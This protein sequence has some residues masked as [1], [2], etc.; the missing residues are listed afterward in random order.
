[1]LILANISGL[2]TDNNEDCVITQIREIVQLTICV[3]NTTRNLNVISKNTPKHYYQ[4]I[5]CFLF[6][7]VFEK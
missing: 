2:C 5:H 3:P 4:L 7:N 6:E 1:M